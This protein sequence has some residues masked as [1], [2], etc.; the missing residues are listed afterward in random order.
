MEDYIEAVH[1]HKGCFWRGVR[2]KVMYVFVYSI[3]R[4]KE[5]QLQIMG[6][7]FWSC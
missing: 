3:T 4:G 7:V 6:F 2:G 5:L 1:M